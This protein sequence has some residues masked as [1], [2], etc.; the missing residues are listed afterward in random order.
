VTPTW[1]TI[2]VAVIA[3]VGGGL[4]A[5]MMRISYERGAELRTRMV[6]AADE[7]SVA[8][9]AARQRMRTLA[10]LILSEM[11]PR[12]VVDAA[13]GWYTQDFLARTDPANADID[14]VLAT[15]SR[16]HLLFGDL[17]V[18]GI[19]GTAIEHHLRLMY[20]SITVRPDSLRNH[21]VFARYSRNFEAVQA[22]AEA[23]NRAALDAL[24]DTIPRRALRSVSSTARRLSS[25]RP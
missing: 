11:P 20:S 5:T 13:T 17:S 16:V 3:G 18:A 6:D 19:A 24:R 14:Q 25:W 21:D 22:Q 8:V 1:V 10:G 4:L 2:L 7:F 9:V 15:L 12:P 23:F